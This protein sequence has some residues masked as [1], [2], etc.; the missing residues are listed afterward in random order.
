MIIRSIGELIRGRTLHAIYAAATVT[1][2]C[3]RLREHRVGALAVEEGGALIGIISERD[4]IAR[5]IAVGLDPQLTLVR[6]VMTP[7]SAD[8][9]H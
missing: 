4:V 6:A 2:V 9:R 7:G 5:M 1:E 8:D 3:R